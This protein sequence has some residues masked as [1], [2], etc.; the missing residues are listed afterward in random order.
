MA[1]LY[2]LLLTG[3][4]LLLS[5]CLSAQ[6]VPQAFNYQAIARN[7]RGEVLANQ[8][9]GL[10]VTIIEVDGSGSQN[11]VYVEERAFTTNQFV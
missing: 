9:L 4:L 10:R 3:G 7:D 5:L 8:D 11:Q 6:D 2:K 1:N